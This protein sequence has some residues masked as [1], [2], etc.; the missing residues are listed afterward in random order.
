MQLTRFRVT[1]YRNIWD[2]GWIDINAITAFVGQNEAGKS[3]LFEALY[4]INPFAPK[5][6]YSIDEDWPVDDW[7]NKDASA[8]VCEAMFSLDAAETADLYKEAK[9]PEPPPAEPVDG[10]AP[11]VER[12]TTL[13]SGLVVVGSRSYSAGPTFAATGEHAKDLDAAKVDAWAK[14]H[15]PK[16]V[17]I[18]DYGLSGTQIELNQL[19]ERFKS[20]KWHQLSNEEQTIKIVLDLA[21]VDID[22]FLAKGGTPEGRTVRSFDKRAAS[23]YLSKQFRDLWTQKKVSFHIE[24]DGTT[25]NIFAEDDAVRMPVR[26]HRRSSGFRWHVSFAWKFTHA[27]RGEY[28]GCI[29]LLEEPGIHLHYSGQRDLLEVFQ[30]LSGSNT[31]LYTTHLASMVDPAYPERVRIVENNDNHTVVKKGVVSSQRAPMAVIELA[32]GLTGDMSG[33]L[34]ARQTLIVEGGDDAMILHKLSGIL[35]GQGKQHLSDRIYLWPAQGASKT[36]MYAA[37]AVGQGWDSG[38]LLDSDMEGLAVKKKIDELVLKALAAEQ[39]ACFRVLMLEKAAGIKK[40][41]AAIEDLFH[42]Q[43][44]IDSVNAAFGIAIRPEDLPV[45]GSDMITKRVERVLIQRYG[46][47]ELDKR[48]VMSEILR[49]FDTWQK[50]ADMPE[51]TVAKTTL[52]MGP[53]MAGADDEQDRPGICHNSKKAEL[54]PGEDKAA[55]WATPSNLSLDE[56]AKANIGPSRNRHQLEALSEAVFDRRLG[57]TPLPVKFLAAAMKYNNRDT[58][59]AFPGL[60][61]LAEDIYQDLAKLPPEDRLKG[62]KLAEQ[63]VKNAASLARK[64]GY[65]ISEK[66]GPPNGG[67][68]VGH[69]AFTHPDPKEKRAAIAAYL[70]WLPEENARKSAKRGAEN[71]GNAPS[72][73]S[74]CGSAPDDLSCSNGADDHSGGCGNAQPSSVVMR[75]QAIRP[76]HSVT[77]PTRYEPVGA[78]APGA[79]ASRDLFAGVDPSPREPKDTPCKPIPPNVEEALAVYN[80]AAAAHG[81]TPCRSPTD[82]QVKRLWKRLKGIGGI[83]H[84]K[85]ALGAL[86]A[87]D[88]LMGRVKPRDG[89][90]PFRLNLERLLR[91]DGGLGDVLGR[92]LGLADEIGAA[93]APDAPPDPDAALKALVASPFGQRILERN[94]QPEGMKILRARLDTNGKR[95]G[96]DA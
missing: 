92:L 64:C 24:I 34:G 61:A 18:Q 29:L 4:R 14:K 91:T 50:L 68:A 6:A 43:F 7:G 76:P 44:Y 75:S 25:L 65:V 35:R 3:N 60:R 31:I 66:R 82:V 96:P 52:K 55:L 81:F 79:G 42:D 93:A 58:G 88:F 11:A 57:E 73:F 40:T 89:G 94:G 32:L 23:S 74:T 22:E 86:P 2:S 10:E 21:K 83:R 9:V 37:F 59:T 17:L 56:A 8:V 77:E 38:V 5:E 13:P 95:A 1:K 71:Q 51:G 90:K 12:S 80:A 20:V 72:D 39:K 85:R 69:Y 67:R 53:G 54:S 36:P 49:R 48:R 30:R 28:K 78:D 19:A 87:D 26:L 47:K 62:Q 46:H 41:D 16:F 63:A 84:F 15:A 45:D 27:S 33:L 70:R